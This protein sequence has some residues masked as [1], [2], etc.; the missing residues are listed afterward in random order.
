M[1]NPLKLITGQKYKVIKP[2]TDYDRLEH[3]VD[4]TWT[5]VRTNFIPYDDG[6]TLHV[7]KEKISVEIVYKLQWKEEE[8]ANLIENFKDYVELG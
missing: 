8:Q 6:L 5:F 3:P 7:M 4:E 2:F 1:E